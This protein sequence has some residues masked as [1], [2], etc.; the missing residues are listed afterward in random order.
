[1]EGN[2]RLGICGPYRNPIIHAPY[3]NIYNMSIVLGIYLYI[4]NVFM[5]IYF[6]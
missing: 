4:R 1:M 6:A 3:H 5:P 2:G